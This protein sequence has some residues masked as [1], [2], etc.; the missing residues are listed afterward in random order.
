MPVC[1]AANGTAAGRPREKPA[2]G[3]IVE[4]DTTHASRAGC[5]AGG[6]EEL[7]VHRQSDGRQR[8]LASGCAGEAT[9]KSRS[10]KAR[11]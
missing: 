4:P 7:A 9:L 5:A 3:L 2:Q 1:T 6:T 10:R 8:S 11:H